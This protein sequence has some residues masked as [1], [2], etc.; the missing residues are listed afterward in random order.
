MPRI[1]LAIDASGGD[2]APDEIIAGA[3]LGAR[4]HPIQ[5]TLVGQSEQIEA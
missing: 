2:Y 1:R 4:R 5:L 3:I